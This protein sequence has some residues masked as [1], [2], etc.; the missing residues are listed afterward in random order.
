[1]AEVT[2][3]QKR[4]KISSKNLSWLYIGLLG[5]L[6]GCPV[7][8]NVHITQTTWID[9]HDD[10]LDLMLLSCCICE[11]YARST[12]IMWYFG[13]HVC[14]MPLWFKWDLFQTPPDLNCFT[15]YKKKPMSFSPRCNVMVSHLDVNVVCCILP[16]Y[17]YHTF[18]PQLPA[19]IWVN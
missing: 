16:L 14:N 7:Q 6:P 5:P 15:V 19:S 17:M 8:H 3:L 11:P 1:M 4:G 9:I 18:G 12:C 13:N 2:T 10:L